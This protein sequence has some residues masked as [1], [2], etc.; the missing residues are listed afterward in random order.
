MKEWSKGSAVA[1]KGRKCSTVVP[2]NGEVFLL[3][4]TGHD[5]HAEISTSTLR[6]GTDVAAWL[7]EK[8]PS[9]RTSSFL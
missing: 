5:S 2:R 1:D 8:Y 4:A 7:Y 3:R 9:S 6:L